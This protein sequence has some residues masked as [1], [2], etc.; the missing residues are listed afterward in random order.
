MYS[1]FINSEKIIEW[2]HSPKYLKQSTHQRCTTTLASSILSETNFHWAPLMRAEDW[3]RRRSLCAI[4]NNARKIFTI[5]PPLAVH[6]TTDIFRLL[7]FR[8]RFS[9]GRYD[10][11][12]TRLHFAITLYR[13]ACSSRIF[14]RNWRAF[15]ILWTRGKFSTRSR[16]CITTT[17]AIRIPFNK[18]R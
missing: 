18:V 8:W 16:R 13:F 15:C 11:F 14:R 10:G 6:F 2:D 9:G 1:G 17:R 7:I 12:A 4:F 3:S 5:F